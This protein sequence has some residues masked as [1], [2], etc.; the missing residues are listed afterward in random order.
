M[1]PNRP[2]PGPPY[3]HVGVDHVWRWLLDALAS[4]GRRH[5][6]RAIVPCAYGPTA[7]LVGAD[8]LEMSVTDSDADPPHAVQHASP[9]AAPP[10]AD[11]YPPTHP[12]DLGSPSWR[13]S[14]GP[15]GKIQ[16]VGGI[17]T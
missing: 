8:G 12:G 14:G 9:Q 2:L 5:L 13:A 1:A 7:A 10:L 16:E 6:I 3:P 15:P 17:I 4:A 11:V